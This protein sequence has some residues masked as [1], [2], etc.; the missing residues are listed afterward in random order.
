MNVNEALKYY[1]AVQEEFLS[2]TAL[3]LIYSN[4]VPQYENFASLFQMKTIAT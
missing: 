1:I 2:Y 4:D 3:Q